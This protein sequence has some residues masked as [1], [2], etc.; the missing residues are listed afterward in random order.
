MEKIRTDQK[1]RR[2]LRREKEYR[3]YMASDQYLKE[4][5]HGAE[6]KIVQAAVDSA[7]GLLEEERKRAEEVVRARDHSDLEKFDRAAR[8]EKVVSVEKSIFEE[9][10]A[11]A[12][13]E[14]LAAM[15]AG[16]TDTSSISGMGAFSHLQIGESTS[17]MIA[18]HEG[19]TE[20][21][22]EIVHGLVELTFLVSDKRFLLEEEL[23]GKPVRCV[24]QDLKVSEWNEW[25]QLCL[26]KSAAPKTEPRT[27]AQL[28]DQRTRSFSA[29]SL[30]EETPEQRIA[31]E[32]FRF[33]VQ[34]EEKNEMRAQQEVMGQVV[35]MLHTEGSRLRKIALDDIRRLYDR[36]VEEKPL[37]RPDSLPTS[38]SDQHLPTVASDHHGHHRTTPTTP[39]QAAD[40]ENMAS[41]TLPQG[42]IEVLP[43]WT[44]RMPCVCSFI[45]GDELSGV[46]LLT[47]AVEKQVRHT[48][49]K[50]GMGDSEQPAAPPTSSKGHDKAP[51]VATTERTIGVVRVED[52]IRKTYI[53]PRT[54]L[55]RAHP[56]VSQAA[57]GGNRAA[58]RHGGGGK[59]APHHRLPPEDDE[60]K[61][62]ESMVEILAREIVSAHF[63]NLH[64]V[65]AGKVPPIA[66]AHP[67]VDHT[68]R[69]A[70]VGNK[71]EEPP[72][73]VETKDETLHC[74]YLIGFPESELFYQ[75]LEVRMAPAIE[76]AEAE[77]AVEQHRIDEQEAA[78]KAA[79]MATPGSRGRS[80]STTQS[81]KPKPPAPPNGGNSGR[82]KGSKN[83][84]VEDTALLVS[85]QT[86]KRAFPPL[87]ILGYFVE[88]D[89]PARQ[90]RLRD[91]YTLFCGASSPVAATG[92]S[93]KTPAQPAASP[94]PAAAASLSV[95]SCPLLHP[96][97]NPEGPQPTPVATKETSS[98]SPS[99]KS[100]QS[101]NSVAKE[102][103]A[104]MSG[105][106][107][108]RK[109]YS[110]TDWDIGTVRRELVL[111]HSR[112]K[113][114]QAQW[115]QALSHH[116][117]SS[118]RRTASSVAA[119]TP[120]EKTKKRPAKGGQQSSKEAVVETP[121]DVTPTGKE[122]FTFPKVLYFFRREIINDFLAEEGRPEAMDHTAN[123]MSLEGSVTVTSPQ[124][125]FYIS[126]GRDWE[127]EREH[128]VEVMLRKITESTRPHL[129]PL[130]NAQLVPHM[131]PEPLRLSDYRLPNDLCN[132]LILSY[133]LYEQKL[134]SPERPIANA[135][136]NAN[137]G[138]APASTTSPVPDGSATSG[139]TTIVNSNSS[140]V[141]GAAGGAGATS[142]SAA[143]AATTTSATGAGALTT[144]APSVS[145]S[146]G[147]GAGGLPA[148]SSGGS[149]A[150]RSPTS[151]ASPMYGVVNF[152][153]LGTQEVDS[154]L[155]AYLHKSDT[156][157]AELAVYRAFSLHLGG[158]LQIVAGEAFP[159]SIWHCS[160]DFSSTVHYVSI[161]KNFAELQE[162]V[163]QMNDTHREKL[164]WWCAVLFRYVI[165]DALEATATAME[166]I[167]QW[168][169]K[170][171]FPTD[172][173]VI[174]GFATSAG[175]QVGGSTLV[176]GNVSIGSLSAAAS[177]NMAGMSNTNNSHN[178][179]SSV[180]HGKHSSTAG[181]PSSSNV[182]STT[183]NNN[184]NN[185]ADLLQ[186]PGNPMLVDADSSAAGAG[187]GATL[188]T[189]P[190]KPRTRRICDEE[191]K[192]SLSHSLELLG[193]LSRGENGLRRFWE[194]F[195]PYL[196]RITEVLEKEMMDYIQ[197]LAVHQ[198]YHRQLVAVTAA[199]AAVHVST[200]SLPPPAPTA[201]PKDGKGKASKEAK[202]KSAGGSRASSKE[203]SPDASNARKTAPPS[204]PASASA[205]AP[206]PEVPLLSWCN[207]HLDPIAELQW[208]SYVPRLVKIVLSH[209]FAVAE[210][211][212][213]DLYIA[214]TT[215]KNPQPP[216]MSSPRQQ[217]GGAGGL[218]PSSNDLLSAEG[219]DVGMFGTDVGTYW[220]DMANSTCDVAAGQQPALTPLDEAQHAVS[221][222]VCRCIVM[223]K[224]LMRCV[225]SATLSTQKWLEVMYRTALA[226]PTDSV[227]PEN[228]RPKTLAQ[229]F[230]V[231]MVAVESCA[232]D[233]LP[234]CERSSLFDYDWP[235][236]NLE[237]SLSTLSI[238]G[239]RQLNLEEFLHCATLAQLSKLWVCMDINS[240]SLA[241]KIGFPESRFGEL[242]DLMTRPLSRHESE[243]GGSIGA[244]AGAAGAANRSGHLPDLLFFTSG[245]LSA[246]CRE[247]QYRGLPFLHLSEL[248]QLFNHS[249]NASCGDQQ[250]Q[251][252]RE[253]LLDLRVWLFEMVS[254]RC[255][256]C[257]SAGCSYLRRHSLPLPSLRE[258][259]KAV[260]QLPENVLH[261]SSPVSLIRPYVSKRLKEGLQVCDQGVRMD[262]WDYEGL[263]PTEMSPA[264]RRSLSRITTTTF[265][266]SKSG[267]LRREY[268]PLPLVLRLFSNNTDSLEDTICRIYHCLAA[269]MVKCPEPQCFFEAGGASSLA[270]NDVRL[271]VEE[272]VQFF[273]YTAL[274]QY[275]SGRRS[276]QD[277]ISLAVDAQ[278][279]LQIE[280]KDKISLAMLLSS[281]WGRALVATHLSS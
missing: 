229:L 261:S 55:G 233:G 255:C 106:N 247:E 220:S 159:D 264:I 68:P 12:A 194:S 101:N 144:P 139:T 235:R 29:S 177:P 148:G 176:N 257:Q 267:V 130:T 114:W 21:C 135:N 52:G 10:K 103:A 123:A 210:P 157:Q 143:A 131:L 108:S 77:I 42:R 64:L 242:D 262:W 78:L 14:A 8:L 175:T 185:N 90:Q 71:K 65:S 222:T 117:L 246:R 249:V 38:A 217:G 127:A 273:G 215:P 100:V 22:R 23:T 122:T 86:A 192:L 160:T 44:H 104:M 193:L 25:L 61:D 225:D 13:A 245:F 96:V 212:G 250:V 240:S 115:K 109:K 53:T 199:M 147:G 181:S 74:L 19:A 18:K 105:T 5:D 172:D 206:P 234:P 93:T 91:A 102:S 178:H 138:S 34:Q 125:P 9:G 201:V 92:T 95:S 73:A 184:N 62:F 174:S 236:L 113:N 269:I 66:A 59:G 277:A 209:L 11:T 33:A 151:M 198:E 7:R 275:G 268:P 60:R 121:T 244:V 251:R 203:A 118:F 253:P 128:A 279:L 171:Y 69:R 32:Q 85:Q 238:Y 132:D 226:T 274:E 281:H 189:H 70:R 155:L 227:Y 221:P 41:Q 252:K 83:Q 46:R 39:P 173:S 180:S 182:H 248:R 37:S 168:I 216:P 200:T 50:G 205:T 207:K 158:L 75:M 6:A 237:L 43:R 183:L 232:A 76:T 258:L 271:T 79:A 45:H 219:S 191:F 146:K 195:Q 129:N 152:Q 4:G 202:S 241:E 31:A 263:A 119:P 153:G 162:S 254:R 224:E 142:P 36:A 169:K 204:G 124:C 167:Y 223:V 141:A 47:E 2:R 1:D 40:S 81:P 278:L 26:H 58:A 214:L 107:S 259:R 256:F 24:E 16:E 49:A 161:D 266:L 57:A 230:T 243:I 228:V 164:Q 272:F 208:E 150:L 126:S 72:P 3:R 110:A 15:R 67:P 94:P 165:D 30:V 179:L 187:S 80:H 27:P 98:R 54:L 20:L 133:N 197:Y 116:A 28:Q 48:G 136:A 89:I 63:H 51:T 260:A 84:V 111:R 166:N 170:M 134:V 17:K 218:L 140:A 82:G 211:M 276:L 97:L 112:M 280:N 163:R 88:Y 149:T 231:P 239:K 196:R 186:D 120:R 265:F 137:V 145:S 87:C 270:V 56:T 188:P 35:H 99:E 213:D 190:T 156:L 154:R